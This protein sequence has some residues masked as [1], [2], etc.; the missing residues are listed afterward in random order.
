VAIALARYCD[1]TLRKR[2][3]PLPDDEIEARQ[4]GVITLLRKFSSKDLFIRNY[5]KFFAQRVFNNSSVGVK[6]E[7]EMVQKLCND[8]GSSYASRVISMIRDFNLNTEMMNSFRFDKSNTAPIEVF[9]VSASNWPIKSANNAPVTLPA[10]VTAWISFFD[11]FYHGMFR[12]RRLEHMQHL[13]R[14]DVRYNITDDRSIN[15]MLSAYQVSMLSTFSRKK[16]TTT[17]GEIEKASSIPNATVRRQLKPL[18]IHG[19]LKTSDYSLQSDDTKVWLNPDF[20]APDGVDQVSMLIDAKDDFRLRELAT[21]QQSGHSDA[22]ASAAASGTSDDQEAPSQ[23]EAAP[24]LVTDQEIAEVV[25]KERQ[26]ILQ[27]AVMRIMKKNRKMNITDLMKRTTNEVSSRFQTT[28]P[29]FKTV[30]ASLKQLGFIDFD[31]K[32]GKVEYVP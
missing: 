2:K 12:D 21:G 18:I 30:I 10:N 3:H 31:A 28:Q 27:G 16:T 1:K 26:F 20:T 32:T 14:A 5:E 15:L 23:D 22:P 25:E 8:Q 7:V 6:A 9:A 13:A 19:L 4:R 24:G 29:M 17:L 11:K